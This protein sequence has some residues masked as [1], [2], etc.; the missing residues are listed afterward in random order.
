MYSQEQPPVKESIGESSPKLIKSWK[1]QLILFNKNYPKAA[2]TLKIAGG[3][4][5][6]SMFFVFALWLLVFLGA[7][8]KL[9]SNAK[10]KN[11]HNH[12]ASEIYSSDKKLLGKI[13]YRKPHQCY[14]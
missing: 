3:L 12:T 8:G 14:L 5:A 6:C 9:P 2:L 11:I 4:A 13:L 7:F 10:L 1:E